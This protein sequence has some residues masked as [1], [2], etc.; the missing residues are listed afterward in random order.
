MARNAEVLGRR[1]LRVAYVRAYHATPYHTIPFHTIPCDTKPDKRYHAM[2]T[3][4]NTHTSYIRIYRYLYIHIYIYIYTCGKTCVYTDMYIY[5][6][7]CATP[8]PPHTHFCQVG[9]RVRLHCFQVRCRTHCKQRKKVAICTYK[10]RDKQ[11]NLQ[12]RIKFVDKYGSH[13][14]SP[15]RN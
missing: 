15:I 2:Q 10:N 1:G 3:H 13:K 11:T 14:K 6:Y 12:T 7:M 8:L 5:I 4:A 9:T